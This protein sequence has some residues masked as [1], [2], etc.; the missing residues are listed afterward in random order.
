M[1]VDVPFLVTRAWTTIIAYVEGMLFWLGRVILA[2]FAGKFAHYSWFEVRLC[3]FSVLYI[4]YNVGVLFY[5]RYMCGVLGS[6]KKSMYI[7]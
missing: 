4:D 1:F 5:L 3:T 2:W 6:V 7:K